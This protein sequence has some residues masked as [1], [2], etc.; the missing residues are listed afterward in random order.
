MT[1]EEAKPITFAPPPPEALASRPL[2]APAPRVPQAPL[3]ATLVKTPHQ[4]G[5]VFADHRDE[6]EK[7]VSDRIAGSPRFIATIALK[8]PDPKADPKAGP[9]TL[10][11]NNPGEILKFC[12]DA[13]ASGNAAQFTIYDSLR[14]SFQGNH[15]NE[16]KFD[17]EM[18]AAFLN[19]ATVTTAAIHEHRKEQVRRN[20]ELEGQRVPA[21]V[22]G[23]PSARGPKP[24]PVAPK[25]TWVVNVAGRSVNVVSGTPFTV[26]WKSPV[27][28]NGVANVFVATSPTMGI[29]ESDAPALTINNG[30]MSVA[31]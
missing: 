25:I 13:N 3:G 2:A 11:S 5:E 10:A 21:P 15:L 1:P 28:L 20:L 7:I 22:P 23:P 30:A 8:K 29:I 4:E 14:D 18:F 26:G 6:Y 9:P 16:K 12:E 17:P 31:A 24:A 19:E 27:L